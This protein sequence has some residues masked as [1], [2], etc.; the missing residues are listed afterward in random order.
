MNIKIKDLPM[1]L[2]LSV[3]KAWAEGNMNIQK[4]SIMMKKNMIMIIILKSLKNT[5]MNIQLA[6]GQ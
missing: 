2:P 5:P 6:L 3:L 1:L 4:K